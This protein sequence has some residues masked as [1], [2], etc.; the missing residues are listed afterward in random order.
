MCGSLL[1]RVAQILIPIAAA[2]VLLLS[3]QAQAQSFVGTWIEQG[4]DLVLF[5][6]SS[7][8]QV[9]VG[10]NMDYG[11]SGVTSQSG[12]Y[13]VSAGF[14]DHVY[15]ATY[16]CN[17]KMLPRPLGSGTGRPNSHT[18]VFSGNTV[19]LTKTAASFDGTFDTLVLTPVPPQTR[20]VVGAWNAKG[21]DWVWNFQADGQIVVTGTGAVSQCQSASTAHGTYT[22]SAGVLS[23]SMTSGTCNGTSSAGGFTGLGRYAFTGNTLTA[24][25]EKTS[26]TS[27][28]DTYGYILSPLDGRTTTTTISPT[29]PLPPPSTVQTVYIVP[30]GQLPTAAVLVSPSGTFG[31]ATLVV[32]LDLSKVLSGGAFAGL[33]Q[34]ASGYN[35]YVAALAP[36]GAL[37]LPSDTWFVLPALQS[38]TQLS[39]PIAAYMTGLAQNAT[40]KV[41]ISILS[42]LDVTGLVG[43]EIYIGYGLSDTEMLAAQRY[44][45]V[46]KVQ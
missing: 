19:T 17:G 13:T 14:Y 40:D 41:V 10:T 26:G 16:G 38:W 45:G 36:K 4:S 15:D 27:P 25:V 28:G 43:A 46:Y 1:C 44:R 9:W 30:T 42:G 34:F 20:S 5:F 11:C 35:I 37:G 12:S 31:N 32:T 23:I 3:P 33:G 18:Y 6:D 21:M 29:T 39:L 7:G 22:A 24:F 8:R 2:I